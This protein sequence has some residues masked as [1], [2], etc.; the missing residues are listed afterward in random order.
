M[1]PSTSTFGRPSHSGDR[2]SANAASMLEGFALYASSTRTAP[3]A[4]VRTWQRIVGGAND[5]RPAAISRGVRP[6]EIAAAKASAKF[7]PLCRPA[8]GIAN[9]PEKS[10]DAIVTS[11]DDDDGVV[12]S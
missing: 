3:F 11:T 6:T 2:R 1:S 4:R 5:A 9:V 10:R 7:S 8:I 12:T